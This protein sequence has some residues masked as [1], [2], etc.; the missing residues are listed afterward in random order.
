VRQ[1]ENLANYAFAL[2][3]GLNLAIGVFI[4]NSNGRTTENFYRLTAEITRSA[5]TP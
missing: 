5:L 4:P 2:G 3:L 1:F